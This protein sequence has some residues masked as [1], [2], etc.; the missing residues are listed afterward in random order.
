V[1]RQNRV[2]DTKQRPDGTWDVYTQKGT[3]HAEHVVNA[4]GLW[5][6]EVGRMVGLELP[7]LAMEHQYFITEDLPELKGQKELLHVIDFEAEVYMRQERQGLLLGTYER[8][9]VPWSPRVTPWDFGQDLLPNDLDRLAPSLE[10]G[11][12]HFPVL[13]DAGIRRI[14]NGPFTFAPDGN[15]LIG[16][17]RGL[18][19]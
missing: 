18:R 17:V 5:A 9:G 12:Q 1:V 4:G 6:R 14:V 2:V 16:P 8:A 11:F 13:A 19:N 3:V 10:V 15:P 7:V